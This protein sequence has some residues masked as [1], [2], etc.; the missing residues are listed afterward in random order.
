M[1]RVKQCPFCGGNPKIM[2]REQKYFGQYEDGRKDKLYGFYVK[3]TRCHARGPLFTMYNVPKD[4]EYAIAKA[5]FRW[6]DRL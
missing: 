5:K 4:N 6:N 1:M 3:C 2:V